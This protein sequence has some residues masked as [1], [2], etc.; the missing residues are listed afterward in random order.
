MADSV[1]DLTRVAGKVAT[2]LGFDSIFGFDISESV[3]NPNEY[4]L[5]FYG[6]NSLMGIRFEDMAKGEQARVQCKKL[7]LDVL[8]AAG[9]DEEEA[10]RRADALTLLGIEIA[11]QGPSPTIS[12][13]NMKAFT[14]EEI[15]KYFDAA[16]YANSMGIQNP[17]H[18]WFVVNEEYFAGITAKWN[19]EKN[20][21]AFQTWL[22]ISLIQDSA[23][24]L[25]S[26]F[27]ELK[28]TL[29]EH[30]ESAD[31]QAKEFIK[32]YLPEQLGEEYAKAFYTEDTDKKVREMCEQ[33]RSSYREVISNAEWLSEKTREGL[34]KKLEN[35]KF[36]TGLDAFRQIDPEDAKL[37]GKDIWETRTNLREKQ[38]NDK[39]EALSRPRKINGQ[40]MWV[41]SVNACYWLDNVV[42]MTIA[43]V[44]EP[45][46]SA[47]QDMATNLGGLG[48]VIGHEVGHAFD[49]NGMNWDE[50]GYYNPDWISEE[51]RQALKDRSQKCVDYYNDYTIM[52]VYHV[53]GQKTLSENYADLGSMEIITNIAKTKEDR[54]KLFTN[55]AKIWSS[56][57]SDV[58][59]IEL[60]K[61]DEHSPDMVRCNAVLSS[62][63]AFYETYDIKESDGMYV[64]KDKRVSRW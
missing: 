9:V 26:E 53:D 11:A 39:I 27:D 23:P 17:Y 13:E 10:E 36:V 21:E 59:A 25:S 32:N 61:M 28:Y 49:A 46:F 47:E 33:I 43:I 38:W 40:N 30:T 48:M 5:A 7:A 6:P 51:D 29:G 63:E 1:S 64:E 8:K 60:L 4:A 56:L 55:F 58:Y 18:K 34:L 24:Y 3:D 19:D 50:N 35:L 37:I 45:F 57:N 14:D 12:L 16:T 54:K 42:H 52:G 41:Q 15:S 44:N 2:K 20:I 22:A 62:C 31:E